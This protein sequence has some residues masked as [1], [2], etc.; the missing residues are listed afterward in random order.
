[1]KQFIVLMAMIALGVFLYS[2]IAGPGDSVQSALAA[3]WK[4]DLARHPYAA[5][6]LIGGGAA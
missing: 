1:M 3:Q 2:C 5:A 4:Q 6:L